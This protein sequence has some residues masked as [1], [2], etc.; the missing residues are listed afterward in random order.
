M[1]YW[2]Y[3]VAVSC[4]NE[5][6]LDFVILSKASS[7]YERFFMATS[8]IPPLCGFPVSIHLS[9]TL[10]ELSKLYSLK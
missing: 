4:K 5:L 6:N 7:C 1:S 3:Q 10:V 9:C 2:N 8:S